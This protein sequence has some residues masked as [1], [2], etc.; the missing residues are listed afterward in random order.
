[1]ADLVIPSSPSRRRVHRGSRAQAYDV[2]VTAL[3]AFAATSSSRRQAQPRPLHRLRAPSSPSRRR[4]HRGSNSSGGEHSRKPSS[5][6]RRR[7]HRGTARA[8]GGNA[9]VNWP[10]SPSRRRVHR[11]RIPRHK[12]SGRTL[13]LVAFA[14]T[15]SSR[16]DPTRRRPAP[17]P[18]VAFAATSSS[19]R[20]S[21]DRPG[22]A[23]PLVAFA[24]TSS[25]RRRLGQRLGDRLPRPSS[26][27]RRRVH[28]GIPTVNGPDAERKN[29]R[30]L[31]GDEFIEAW[32]SSS[33]RAKPPGPSSPSRRRVH[34][35]PWT[36][37]RVSLCSTSLVAFAAT[38]S[39]RLRP[40]PHG[41]PRPTDP[42]SPS[43]RRVHRGVCR[44]L[45]WD[46]GCQALVAFAAT[47]SSR[48]RPRR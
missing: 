4:V 38:S 25:S 17:T 7:V 13:T 15:S 27:S 32:C 10:S 48:L 34:R 31:R 23:L 33:V 12:A 9:S 46:A 29:P 3:V 5:P 39:S 44:E 24:A 20:A 45:A 30:R 36:P 14:A 21:R 1:M 26:P 28:R 18:L 19:R 42:S 22:A 2:L 35:G 40:R 41:R 37:R 6:S 8:M 11:G 43:R 47:S 16:R